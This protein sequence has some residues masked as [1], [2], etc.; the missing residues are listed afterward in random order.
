VAKVNYG[1]YKSAK[2]QR[3]P[4]GLVMTLL[5]VLAV[6]ALGMIGVRQFYNANLSKISESAESQTIVIEKGATVQ[7]V[8]NVLQ[9][10]KLIRSS[11]VFQ[12]YI[13][14]KDAKNPLIAGT[15]RLQPNLTTPQ[16][17]SILS[18][19]R[20]ATDLVTILPGQRLDQIRAGLLK[21]G[22]TAADVDKA[23]DPATYQNNPALVD[24]PA[25]ASLEGYLY[26]DSFQRNAT[27]KPDEIITES[28]SLMTKYLTPDIREAFARHG[29]STYQGLVLASV[30]EQEAA[31]QGDREQVAQ[32]FLKRLG[33]GMGLQSDPTGKYGA[34]L[35]GKGPALGYESAYNTYTHTG[36]PPT[37]ISNVS[38][39]SLKAVAQP[40]N[41]DWVYFVAGDDGKVHFSNTIEEH[42]RLTQ[43][44]CTKLCG[45]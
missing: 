7:E 28:L 10:K 20:V 25:G 18:Q 1:R 36:L 19:G 3:W 26:P 33:V 41:T 14:S 38:V 15:Y 44:Y 39:S 21:Y 27:T 17:V 23:L 16:I 4:K 29:L 8:G 6:V 35:A 37:P 32:V 31:S 22:F 34:I 30:V 24:K 12:L 2:R 5:A 45:N 40:A 13:R 11:L 43:Q 9:A 42:E